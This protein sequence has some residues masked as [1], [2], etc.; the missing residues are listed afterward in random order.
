MSSSVQKWLEDNEIHEPYQS[1]RRLSTVNG[2]TVKVSAETGHDR[3]AMGLSGPVS[4]QVIQKRWGEERIFQN[5]SHYCSKLLIIKK[6]H[7]TS[8]HFHID[9]HET[10]VVVSGILTIDY[11]VD[12][13][14]KTSTVGPYEAFVIAPGLPHT[15]KAI[16]G[17]VHLIESSM[18]SHDSDSIRIG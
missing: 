10:M 13:E 18:P 11:I 5:N 3:G 7:Q 16:D 6:G 4:P 1:A 17:D 8:M 9:K 2:V 12:K 15:L 14:N